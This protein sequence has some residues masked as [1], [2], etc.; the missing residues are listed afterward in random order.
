MRVE[1][2]GV[3]CCTLERHRQG[4]FLGV[5]YIGL[6]VSG[7]MP[8]KTVPSGIL[9]PIVGSVGG[10]SFRSPACRVPANF[11]TNFSLGIGERRWLPRRW[12]IAFVLSARSGGPDGLAPFAGDLK[13]TPQFCQKKSDARRKP[14]ATGSFHLAV[15]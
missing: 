2:G 4:A 10:A 3:F 14:L 13:V 12:V 8:A 1:D 7:E 15:E 5:A 9:S 11:A 6:F